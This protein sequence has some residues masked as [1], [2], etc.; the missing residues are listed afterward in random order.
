[1]KERAWHP[2]RLVTKVFEWAMVVYGAVTLQLEWVAGGAGLM[3]VE[4][5]VGPR[6]EGIQRVQ[7]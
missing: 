6:E 2:S 5:W 3:L 7:T 4:K 1:M